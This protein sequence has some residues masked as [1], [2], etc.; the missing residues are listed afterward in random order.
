MSEGGS[1]DG[2]WMTAKK[3]ITLQ[4]TMTKKEVIKK[5]KCGR[6]SEYKLML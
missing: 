6:T 1:F 4:R 5:F 3:V 2:T